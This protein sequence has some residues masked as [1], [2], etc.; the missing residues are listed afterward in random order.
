MRLSI[1]PTTSSPAARVRAADALVYVPDTLLGRAE[2]VA[3][4]R[5][6]SGRPVTRREL[7]E[8]LLREFSADRLVAT[9]HAAVE[10]AL[11]VEP[12]LAFGAAA[13]HDAAR[14]LGELL[15]A[16]ADDRPA[17][18]WAAYDALFSDV[19]VVA[20]PLWAGADVLLPDAFGARSSR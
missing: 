15:A 5:A 7:L 3:A 6:A 14:G 1:E 10:G 9:M 18:A 4:A 19:N 11:A 13:M 2:L 20:A 12:E 8:P 17:E 16:R